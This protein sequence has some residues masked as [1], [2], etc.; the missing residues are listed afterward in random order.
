MQALQGQWPKTADAP[1]SAPQLKHSPAGGSVG[2]RAYL[3]ECI[4]CSVLESQLRRRIVD[5]LFTII[6]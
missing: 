2:S 6:D 3:T 1:R 4:Y 5:P